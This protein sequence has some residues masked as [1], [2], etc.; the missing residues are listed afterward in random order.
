MVQKKDIYFYRFHTW[1]PIRGSCNHQ[2]ESLKE[3]ENCL[4][5]DRRNCIKQGNYSDRTLHQIACYKT[6][7]NGQGACTCDFSEEIKKENE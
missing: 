1:G 2:H 5:Q 4:E 3:A 6:L 7:N